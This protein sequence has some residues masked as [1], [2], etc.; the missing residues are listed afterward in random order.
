MNDS[1]ADRPAKLVVS[2]DDRFMFKSTGIV[3]LV[4]ANGQ[5]DVTKI[6]SKQVR[7]S[8]EL[9]APTDFEFRFIPPHAPALAAGENQT[10]QISG[11]R[12]DTVTHSPYLRY[13]PPTVPCSRFF[14]PFC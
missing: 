12:P 13:P 6:L 2:I 14:R 11:L 1:S 7:G 5:V 10:S 8:L 4:S 9:A 3:E